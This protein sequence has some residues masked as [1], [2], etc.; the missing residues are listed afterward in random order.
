MFIKITKS[1]KYKY[2]QVVKSFKKDGVTMHKKYFFNLGRLDIIQNSPS[3][4]NFEKNFFYYQ[5]HKR[6]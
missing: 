1:G 3:F 6:H 5:K 4:S 2:C